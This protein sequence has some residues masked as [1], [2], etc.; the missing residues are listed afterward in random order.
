MNE[1]RKHNSRNHPAGDNSERPERRISK[2]DRRKFVDRRSNEERR[3]DNRLA[4]PKQQKSINSWLRSLVNARL[5]V[6]RRKKADRR[7]LKDRRQLHLGS[8]LTKEEIADLLSD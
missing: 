1:E 4:P 3:C 6:D 2:L 5:G 8:L 7:S